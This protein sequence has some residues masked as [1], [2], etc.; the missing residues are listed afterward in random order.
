MRTCWCGRSGLRGCSR[1]TAW[2]V[3]DGFP[4]ADRGHLRCFHGV[5]APPPD[6]K[7]APFGS[8]SKHRGQ[9]AWKTGL[10]AAIAL[11]DPDRVP[12][13]HRLR[14]PTSM[15]SFRTRLIGAS[16]LR[17]SGLV[18][19]VAAGH[20]IRSSFCRAG[21]VLAT[22][23]VTVPDRRWRAVLHA[24]V[25]LIARDDDRGHLY[26]LA[27]LSRRFAGRRWKRL[28]RLRPRRVIAII[29]P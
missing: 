2:C 24:P 11:R 19:A 18:S 28:C 25:F 27:R 22:I 1:A 23:F 10:C 20:H 4:R 5:L 29:R 9:A 13:L 6:Q 15:S 21:I 3:I 26:A 17:P 16:G 8:S 14:R 12:R 7:A